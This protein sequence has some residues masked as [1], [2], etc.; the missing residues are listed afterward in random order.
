MVTWFSSAANTVKEAFFPARCVGCD[1]ICPWPSPTDRSTPI[2]GYLCL[3]C[4]AQL[5][6]IQSPHCLTCGRPFASD[7]GVDHVCGACESIAFA[8]ESARAAGLYTDALKALIH[9]Y[10]YRCCEPLAAPLGRL[11][12]DAFWRHWDLDDIDAIVPVPLHWRRL[13]KRGFNQARLLLRKWPRL[14]A[15]SGI[16]FDRW[17]IWTDLLVRRR[18]TLPQTGLDHKARQ[19]NM[20]N[21]F[22]I[23]KGMANM[24]KGL[25]LLLVDDVFTTGATA[26]A[27]AQVLKRDGGAASVQLLTLA[28]AAQ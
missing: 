17:P 4:G 28:R 22:G 8:F 14:A 7:Q 26:H 3:K 21:A 18:Y 13:R 25:R 6:W 1:A 5:K 15:Q 2:T 19:V 27:C 16:V 12:W 11:L 24:A 20:R 9:H 10:K 23:G